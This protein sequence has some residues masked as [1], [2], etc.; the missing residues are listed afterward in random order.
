MTPTPSSR[1]AHFIRFLAALVFVL[2]SNQFSAQ[3]QAPTLI[4]HE[5]VTDQNGHIL[6][7]YSSNLGES[8]DHIIN[9]VWNYWI[10]MP[11]ESN[12]IPR[13][14]QHRIIEQHVE[15]GGD[16]L[17]M[18][19]SSWHLLYQYSGDQAVLD[20]MKYIANFY[21]DYGLSSAASLWP[22]IPFPA[23]ETGDNPVRTGFFN[24][25]MIEGVGVTQ[26][27]KAGSFGAELVTLYKMTNAQRYLSSAIK[28]ANTLAGKVIPG[29]N[30]HSPLPF[31]VNV[32]TGQIIG[33]YTTNWTGTL[34]LFDGLIALNQGNV[35][36]YTSARDAISAWLKTYP[37][38]THKWGPFFEDISVWS[39][40]EINADT[41]AWYVLEHPQWDA[42]WQSIARDILNNTESTFGNAT[43]NGINW[44]QYGVLPIGEQSVYMVPGNSHTSRHGSVELIYAAKTGDTT[45][46]AGAIREL[47]WATYMVDFDGANRYPQNAVWLTDGYGDYVRHYLRAMAAAPELAPD[48]ENHLLQSSSVVKS[49]A[50]QTNQ[51]S[52]TTFDTRST[53]LLKLAFIPN[54][55]TVD[56]ILLTK[57]TNLNAEGWVFDVAS[58]VLR[59]RHDA[60]RQVVVSRLPDPP[61]AAPRLYFSADGNISLTWN[62]VS[63]ANGYEIQVDSNTNFTPPHYLDNSNL[64]ANQLSLNLTN[65]PDGTYYW[66]VRGKDGNGVWRTWTSPQS[67]RVLRPES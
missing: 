5:I 1:S 31:K 61:Y 9:L 18:A 56:G 54:R 47:N 67:F 2:F 48:G 42:N 40:T 8:Y 37:I 11:N 13:Y 43:W 44:T 57:R 36:S 66:R 45:R 35:A 22:N 16:Q 4:F 6:P 53:E 46:K 62:R 21:L 65:V 30:D 55:V 64:T 28:I 49:I 26:P 15:I 25:D 32:N 52:F 10:S 41:L 24:G 50:Y 14:L 39:D 27:D 34:Q 23:N 12:G 3:A 59:I 63:W 33:A 58:G 29:D 19:L 51:V 38:T 60:G 20:N 17:A 7:W